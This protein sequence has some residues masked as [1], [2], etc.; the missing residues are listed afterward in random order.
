MRKDGARLLFS[1]ARFLDRRQSIL[2]LHSSRRRCQGNAIRL[3]QTWKR[4]NIMNFSPEHVVWDRKDDA[5][6]TW[7]KSSDL[8]LPLQQSMSLYYYQGWAKAFREVR[9]V[10]ALRAR[11]VNG[12]EY[13]CWQWQPSLPAPE[14]DALQREL[15]RQVPRR[16]HMEWLPAIQRDLAEWSITDIA[17]LAERR[18]GCVSAPDADT[19]ALPLGNPRLHGFRTARRGAEVDRLVPGA[20]PGGARE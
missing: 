17:T 20:L 19:P 12:Y 18:V 5:E 16:W 4:G 13:R 11:F 10:G 14:T 3:R 15:E 7:S 8:V 9:V 6:L 2:V 1:A